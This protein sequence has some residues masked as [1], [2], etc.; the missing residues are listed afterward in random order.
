M[1][2]PALVN[3]KI[4]PTLRAR[5]GVPQRWRIVNAAK[6]RFFLLNLD[7]QPF[8]V[9]G[10]DGGLQES[11]ETMDTLLI[12]PGERADVIVTPTGPKSGA[13]TLRADLYNRGYGSVEYRNPEEVLTI[14]FTDQPTLPKAKMR[15]MHREI[16]APSIAGATN[17]NLVLS[18]PPAGPD[19]KSE[20]RVNGVPF[21]KA[22]PFLATLGEKQ[23]F[24]FFLPLDE[25]LEPIHPMA[26]KDTSP[27]RWRARSGSWWSLTSDLAC[28]CSIVT[29]STTRTA[30]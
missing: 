14:A 24:F 19:G 2:T 7:G 16:A 30:G 21:W 28:E 3:G 8:Y 5:S 18:L 26:W 12:T 17:V 25:K 20:F 27:Y 15:A 29:S 13:L 10:G 23:I 22:K 11:P 6:S 4:M 1:S 9:I